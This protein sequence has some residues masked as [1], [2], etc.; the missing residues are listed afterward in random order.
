MH[1]TEINSVDFTFKEAETPEKIKNI[2]LP[3]FCYPK[4][5]EGIKMN[6]FLITLRKG[7][8]D[9]LCMFLI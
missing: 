5:G 8:G 2:L 3:A 9:S 7:M 6:S 1:K 4:Q